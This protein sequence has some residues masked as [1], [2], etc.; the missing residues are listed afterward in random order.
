MG[1]IWYEQFELRIQLLLEQLLDA[2]K[3]VLASTG[4][5]FTGLL[6]NFKFKTFNFLVPFLV[7]IITFA[8]PS[9]FDLFRLISIIP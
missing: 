4:G 7:R 8:F 5:F 6:L 1:H 2:I 9:L 3:T